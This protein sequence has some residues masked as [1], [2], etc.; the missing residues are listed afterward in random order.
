[1]WSSVWSI[2]RPMKWALTRPNFRRKNFIPSDQFPYE[3]P[4]LM[5]YD[6]G[7]YELLLDK[8]LDLI[9]YNGFAARKAESEKNGKL[10]GIGFSCFVES[11]GLAPVGSRRRAR[12][13]RRPVGIVQ[14]QVRSDRFRDRL[15]RQ[16][17][18][19]PGP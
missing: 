12:W 11:C 9:D 2:S 17:L 16:P 18:A 7:N 15:Y 4:V 5:T 10:R 3:T 13:R 1:M 19:R 14:R 8:G 6:S